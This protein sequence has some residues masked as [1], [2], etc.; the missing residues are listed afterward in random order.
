MHD[1]SIE[2]NLDWELE[3]ENNF[4]RGVHSLL[5]SHMSDEFLAVE[6]TEGVDK[7]VSEAI[8]DAVSENP[9][10]TRD[11]SSS[12]LLGAMA[13]A[14]PLSTASSSGRSNVAPSGSFDA[15]IV[16]GHALNPLEPE[17]V[18]HFWEKG[19]WSNVFTDSDPVDSMFPKGLERPL[20]FF[21]PAADGSVG[22]DPDDVVREPKFVSGSYHFT[23]VIS[24]SYS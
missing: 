1:D 19:F 8:N 22:D 23:S 10:G 21:E 2:D 7:S 9:A 15:D 20:S 13:K 24:S 12:V 5:D 11:V 6:E 4:L 16:L 18:E 14:K 3:H 17:R